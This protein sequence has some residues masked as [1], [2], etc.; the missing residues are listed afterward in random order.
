M[1]IPSLNQFPLSLLFV[2][3]LQPSSDHLQL[4]LSSSKLGTQTFRKGATYKLKPSP[5]DTTLLLELATLTSE[6]SIVNQ[7]IT[8]YSNCHFHLSILLTFSPSVM[9]PHKAPAPTTK[10]N[11][12]TQAS[13][14]VSPCIVELPPS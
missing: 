9:P 8:V 12:E 7:S 4:I 2:L 5:S 6:P 11:K 14:Q 13:G 10:A 3:T 1:L